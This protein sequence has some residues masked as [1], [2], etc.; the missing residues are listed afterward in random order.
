MSQPDTQI[1]HSISLLQPY[2]TRVQ[3]Q[4][5]LFH[6]NI[7]KKMITSVR[8]LPSVVVFT[9]VVRLMLSAGRVSVCLQ[10]ALWEIGDR[11]MMISN[12]M[13]W[14]WNIK[15]FDGCSC[16]HFQKLGIMMMLV[17]CCV[18]VSKCPWCM[19]PA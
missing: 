3:T 8:N 2:Q 11:T 13:N 1:Q 14:K 19:V 18:Y 7:K 10:H 5:L 17:V 6:H 9:S 4:T 12:D 15:T 16:I